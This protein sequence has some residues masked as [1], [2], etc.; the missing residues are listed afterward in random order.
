[1]L[2]K[3][4]YSKIHAVLFHSNNFIMISKFHHTDLLF[5]STNKIL[6]IGKF[7][8]VIVSIWQVFLMNCKQSG[9][10]AKADPTFQFYCFIFINKK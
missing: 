6:Y 5:F 9:T 10:D 3:N 8:S 4:F 1:M 7:V 2:M